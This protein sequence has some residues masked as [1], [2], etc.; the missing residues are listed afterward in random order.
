MSAEPKLPPIA[1][2]WALSLRAAGRSP[3]T[4]ESYL[5][6][7][8]RFVEFHGPDVLGAT[9]ADIEAFQAAGFAAGLAPATVA[10]RYRSLRQFYRWLDEE[11]EV[12]SS[13][14]ERMKPPTV[15]VQPPEVISD[16]DLRRLLE[17][18]RPHAKGAA[19]RRTNK[20]TDDNFERCRD[21][22]MVLLL[23]TTGIRA[24]ELVG[25]ELGDVDIAR[26]SFRVVG[27][28]GRERAIALVPRAAEAVD[29]YL[30]AR[31]RH[32]RAAST[33][34]LWL[35]LRGPLTGSGLRQ[36]LEARCNAAGI[37]HINPHL[38][39]HTFAH[40]AKVAGVSDE[41][42]MAI[43]GWSTAQMLHRYGASARGERAR[44]EHLR[45]FG[46]G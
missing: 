38:F 19:R 16:D 13:P 18:C 35:G 42:L 31:A 44:D 8:G 9:R 32:P 20:G 43:A 7:L 30:R 4:V 34:A 14:M 45:M 23:F 41:S 10:R 12:E 17:A 15:P 46:D 28:G 25:L 36:A 1:D 29:R 2:S 33:A 21:T 11:D 6:D 37:R 5:A 24:G 3:A 39:R 22:A 40:R 26:Q 27:K